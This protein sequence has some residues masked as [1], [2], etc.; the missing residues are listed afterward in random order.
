MKGGFRILDSD[1]HIQEPT[2]FL[3]EYLEE[4][5]R[6][7]VRFYS[8][9]PPKLTRYVYEVAG[10]TYRLG[11]SVSPDG[12]PMNAIARVEDRRFPLSGYWEKAYGRA[13]GAQDLLEAMDIEGLDVA[14]VFPTHGMGLSSI[15]D[16]DPEQSAAIARAYNNWMHDL[17]SADPKRLKPTAVIS[18]LDANEAAREA[19]RAV[20]ELGA[21]AVVNTCNIVR[22]RQPHD[23]FYDPLWTELNQLEVP[24]CFHPTTGGILKESG[25]PRL[26]LAPHSGT[27]A[28]SLSNPFLNMINV[29]S[30]TVGGIFERYPRLKAA[31]LETSA[32]WL[33]WLL[34]R[35]DDQWELFGP[36]EEW[37]LSMKP[38]DYF[39]RQGFAAV[40]PEESPTRY[41]VDAVGEDC[42]V[43]S[44]DYPHPDGHF[45][46]AMEEFIH[47]PGISDQAKQK[48]LWDNCARLYNLDPETADRR[49][50]EGQA[51]TR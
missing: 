24:I 5:Y 4:P 47:L 27:I 19:R 37:T 45:P 14:V 36:D 34:W 12:A 21:V 8:V 25:H 50:V 43:I 48:I 16:L 10:R 51:A 33:I 30:F 15:D 3:Q 35:L 31:F 6:G 26:Q 20:Q 17:C 11:K 22:D 2:D 44:T 18:R 32:S 41:L 29:S 42:L 40:E 49:L 39:R 23:P 9:S 1:L 46:D 13:F 28:H 7:L 38:S